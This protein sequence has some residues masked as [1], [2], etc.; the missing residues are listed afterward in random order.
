ML[1]PCRRAHPE[2]GTRGVCLAV[3]VLGPE[4]AHVRGEVGAAGYARAGEPARAAAAA[5]ATF[6][7]PM[8]GEGRAQGRHD[9]RQLHMGNLHRGTGVGVPAASSEVAEVVVKGRLEMAEN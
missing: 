4:Q 6:V 2:P 5:P 3:R 9:A 1:R 8:M 7:W